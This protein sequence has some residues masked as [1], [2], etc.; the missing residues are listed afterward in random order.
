[1]DDPDETN[2]LL[3]EIRDL[4]ASREETYA[5][6]LEET[7]QAELRTAQRYEDYSAAAARAYESQ[8]SQHRKD[9]WR[10]LIAW[11]LWATVMISVFSYWDG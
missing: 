3:R 1:M 8:V 11:M 4:I 7:K 9:A 6:Y 10:R 2:A 5:H